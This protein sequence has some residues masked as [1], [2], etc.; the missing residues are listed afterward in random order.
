MVAITTV[1]ITCGRNSTVR[2]NDIDF[3]ACDRE[4]SAL[5]NSAMRTGAAA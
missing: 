3:I 5:R 1:A 4:I 2:K